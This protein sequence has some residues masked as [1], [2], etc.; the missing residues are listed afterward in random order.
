M[1]N[2]TIAFLSAIIVSS[3]LTAM[4]FTSQQITENN[5][6]ILP[7]NPFYFIKSWTQE[8]QDIFISNPVKKAMFHSHLLDQKG[9]EIAI[10]MELEDGSVSEEIILDYASKASNF[11]AKI[12]ELTQTN[13]AENVGLVFETSDQL[14]DYLL[15]RTIVHLELHLE[16][17]KLNKGNESLTASEIDLKQNI[18][19]LVQLDTEPSLEERIILISKSQN[20]DFALQF[21]NE[22]FGS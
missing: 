9:A 22:T 2:I 15:E 3:P 1:K 6:A 18:A 13:V 16:I 11:S 12:N 14:I 19:R 20:S 10:S 17:F 4:A 21:L 5:P 8:F 7:D